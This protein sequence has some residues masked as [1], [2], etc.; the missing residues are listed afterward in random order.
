M[1]GYERLAEQHVR[2]HQCRQLRLD[3]LCA[4]SAAARER[5]IDD[6]TALGGDWRRNSISRAGPM[7]I[8]DVVA[9]DL[10]SFVEL[11][12]HAPRCD[13]SARAGHPG[14]LHCL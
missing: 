7:G 11:F 10:E 8:W 5:R 9:Q 4:Q 13:L 12:E 14:T 3:E 1:I 2:E 6:A